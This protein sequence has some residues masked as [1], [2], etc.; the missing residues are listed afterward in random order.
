M[1]DGIGDAIVIVTSSDC[2]PTITVGR[3]GMTKLSRKNMELE[4]G[5]EDIYIYI[6]IYINVRVMR[7]VIG[8]GIVNKGASVPPT[9]K[10]IVVRR[11][12][13]GRTLK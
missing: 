9:E 12:C 3:G 5:K 10:V 7:A 2:C 1:V 4:L 8:S 11:G 6:Y 13:N